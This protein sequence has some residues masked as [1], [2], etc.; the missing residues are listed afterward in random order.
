MNVTIHVGFYASW[1]GEVWA[2]AAPLPSHHLVG[3][4]HYWD[5]SGRYGK[6]LAFHKTLSRNLSNQ[7]FKLEI[8]T[9][10]SRKNK[11]RQK[12]KFSSF[13]ARIHSIETNTGKHAYTTKSNLRYIYSML[14]IS[15]INSI[16]Y[17]TR[18]RLFTRRLLFQVQSKMAAWDESAAEFDKHKT[19]QQLAEFS[20]DLWGFT[21]ILMMKFAP[22]Y[23]TQ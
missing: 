3:C 17:S 2:A 16:V 19:Q 6:S 22:L 8:I 21:H 23:F 13:H 1:K 10:A 12:T 15:E 7:A 4:L 11:L 5:L 9:Y 18:S 20:A 14:S